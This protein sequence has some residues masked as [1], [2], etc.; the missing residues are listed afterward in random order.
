LE[1]IAFDESVNFFASPLSCCARFLEEARAEAEVSLVLTSL[2]SFVFPAT[3]TGMDSLT[4]VLDSS[5]DISSSRGGGLEPRPL[6][7]LLGLTFPTADFDV[8]AIDLEVELIILEEFDAIDFDESVNFFPS[9]LNCCALFLEVSRILVVGDRRIFEVEA[10]E[11]PSSRVERAA[12]SIGRA[13]TS[14]R[15]L[16]SVGLSFEASASSK[17]SLTISESI[18]DL[19]VEVLEALPLVLSSRVGA[20]SFL[21]RLRDSPSSHGVNVEALVTAECGSCG[22]ELRAIDLTAEEVEEETLIESG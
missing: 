13:V 4:S 17:S 20:A 3:S 18:I 9:P 21:T 16:D 6:G 7:L 1:A 22:L 19:D 14:T 10:G 5:T 12:S 8:D 11:L 2:D 15:A